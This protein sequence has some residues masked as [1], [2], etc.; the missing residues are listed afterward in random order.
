MTN[1]IIFTSKNDE[2]SLKSQNFLFISFS[3][4]KIKIFTLKIF[5]Q[6]KTTSGIRLII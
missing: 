5:A 3:E 6:R 1:L 2:K 4:I